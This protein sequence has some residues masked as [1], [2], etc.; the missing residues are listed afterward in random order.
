M[1]ARRLSTAPAA[2]WRRSTEAISRSTSSGAASRS[3]RSRARAW[4]PSGPSSAR[5][6]TRTLASTTSTVV[7][8]GSHG[9]G[10]RHR[11]AGSPACA[12]K[13]FVQR[14]LARFLDQA[15]AQVLLQR[16]VRRSGTLTQ[17]GM[18]LFGHV[19]DLDTRHNAIMALL[20][21]QCNHMRAGTRANRLAGERPWAGWSP[22]PRR[23]L[24]NRQ[25]WRRVLPV[26]TSSD[27]DAMAKGWMDR[28]RRPLLGFVLPL[29][30][31]DIQAAEDGNDQ[32]VR[33]SGL[34]GSLCRGP[35]ERRRALAGIAAV[36]AAGLLAA[37]G[38]AASSTSAPSQHPGTS[39]FAGRDGVRP[40]AGRPRH[41]P[42]HQVRQHHLFARPGGKRQDLLYRK[43][44]E[45]LVPGDGARR[46]P[47][48][49]ASRSGGHAG[50]DPPARQWHDA[51]D[52]QRQ[53]AVHLPARP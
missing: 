26:V 6:T 22:G 39:G 19:L 3:P 30:D 48:A 38:S 23:R 17:D 24:V 10:E 11:S 25:G 43:L 33:A 49:R 4:S 9:F 34:R 42:R 53:A 40:A 14:G 32:S 15:A 50:H 20:A 21:P 1:V 35:A 29:V 16:L 18:R 28:Y 46:R 44:P 7:V 8:H 45:L 41:R 13:D 31:G 12:V 52:V 51:A 36:A 47:P 5:A 2:A 27:C 37:C